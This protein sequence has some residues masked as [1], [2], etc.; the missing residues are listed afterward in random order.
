MQVA[1]LGVWPRC[2]PLRSRNARNHPAD[3]P[4][5]HQLTLR[6]PRARPLG[7]V[8][9]LSGLQVLADKVALG[10]VQLVRHARPHLCFDLLEWIK[11]D[12]LGIWDNIQGGLAKRQSPGLMNF[13]TALPYHFC[14]ALPKAFTQPGDYL[15]DKPCTKGCLKKRM[16][17]PVGAMHK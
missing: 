7:G 13:V 10:R 1:L 6:R 4:A 12:T 17:T 15:L 5:P 14:L 9:G 11:G 2:S 16:R 3:P 8:G